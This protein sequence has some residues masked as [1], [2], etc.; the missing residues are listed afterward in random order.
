VKIERP[1]FRYLEVSEREF[2]VLRD[3]RTLF[4]K[5]ITSKFHA[6]QCGEIWPCDNQ[7][8]LIQNAKFKT[9]LRQ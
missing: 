5:I 8:L 6:R 4:N 3:F 1:P 9:K 7:I 2:F